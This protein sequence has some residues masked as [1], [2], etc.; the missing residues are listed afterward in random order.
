V[1]EA[2]STGGGRGHSK[3]AHKEEKETQQMISGHRCLVLMLFGY[4]SLDP[5][6]WPPRQVPVVAPAVEKL[7]RKVACPQK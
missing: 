3:P 6:F 4:Y 2:L 7:E 1:G 5:L